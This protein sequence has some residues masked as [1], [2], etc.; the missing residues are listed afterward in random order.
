MTPSAVQAALAVEEAER[1]EETVQL[2]VS[3]FLATITM[4]FAAFTSAYIVRRGGG[5]WHRIEVPATLWLSTSALVLSSAAL[6]AAGLW[7]GRS[8]WRHASAAMAA[9]LLLG[10]MFLGAQASAWRTLIAAGVYLPATP[11]S[12]FFFMMTG[13]HA[14]HVVAALAVLSWA[15]IRTWDGTGRSDRRRWR[16]IM[17]SGRMFWHFLLGV[18]IYLFAL[19]SVL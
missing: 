14:L 16:T 13:A 17:T 6:E 8:R 1:R 5:D 10:L 12:S 19:I 11:H 15:A 4:L 3:M 9:A 7:G 2:G 18:W